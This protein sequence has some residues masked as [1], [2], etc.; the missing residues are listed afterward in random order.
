MFNILSLANTACGV[1]ARLL[2][3][4]TI[5]CILPVLTYGAEAWWPGHSRLK[6]QKMVSARAEAAFSCLEGVFRQAIQ[7]SLPVYWTTSIPILHWEAAIPPWTI[8]LTTAGLWP[9]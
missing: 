1:S 9:T 7:G 2:R 8:Y 5:A 3:H 4:A 6:N